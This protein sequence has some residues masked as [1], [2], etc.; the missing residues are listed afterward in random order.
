MMIVN[1]VHEIYC[2][3]FYLFVK[4]RDTDTHFPTRKFSLHFFW[5]IK[6]LGGVYFGILKAIHFCTTK[7]S[8][9]LGIRQ[10]S[11]VIIFCFFNFFKRRQQQFSTKD[12]DRALLCVE[13]LTRF[14]FMLED[15]VSILEHWLRVTRLLILKGLW[16]FW[17]RQREDT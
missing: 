12:E 11:K 15:D 8:E 5:Y 1:F 3:P 17:I 7:L 6:V 4:S 14:L 9:R 2:Q 13:L 16:F 10:F